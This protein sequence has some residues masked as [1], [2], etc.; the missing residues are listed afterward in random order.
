M[1]KIFLVTIVCSFA[2][3]CSRNAVTGKN[4]LLLVPESEMQT[5]AASQY[6][7]FL[8]TS[9]VVSPS[10]K[11]AAMVR[12]I[13]QRITTAITNYYKAQGKANILDGYTW[14]YNLVESNQVNAWCM[15]GG[16]I[17]VYTGLLPITQNEAALAV[18]MGHE[19]T[20]ALARHGSE[21]MTQGIAQQ[22]G[23][24]ALSVLL[25]NKSQGIQSLAMTAYGVGSNYAVILPFSRNQEYEADQFGLNFA[26]MAG[27]N[28]QEAIPLWQR[29]EQAGGGSR[30]PEFLS[31][32]P[33]EGNRIARLQKQMPEALKYYKPVS[34]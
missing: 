32:H 1:K 25:A 9:K 30:P 18:V 27:Y 14:E 22:Y 7:E 20:H 13:G 33:S 19:I 5:M 11:D 31:T 29:M 2:M 3:A 24:A 17:V 8:D 10:V 26:A 21:R 6:K 28:P 16:K 34:N 4:Q 15:P 23:G 12:R